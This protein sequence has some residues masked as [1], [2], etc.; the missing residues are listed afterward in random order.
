MRDL[1]ALWGTPMVP[2]LC[3]AC[4]WRYL[5]AGDI[6]TDQTCPHCASQ[7]L[8]ELDPADAGFPH[9]YPPEL[10]VPFEVEAGATE[11]RVAAF[12]EEIPF[13]PE[14]LT[15]ARLRDRLRFLFLPMWMVDVDAEAQ[16]QA[17]VGFDYEVVS[18]QERYTDG[19]GW[20][21]EEVRESRIRWEPRVG[22]LTRRYENVVAPALEGHARL[23]RVLGAYEVGR[24]T[25]YDAAAVEHAFVRAPDRAPDTAWTDAELGVRQRAAE[26]C[27]RAADADHIREFRWSLARAEKNWT[28]LLL[29]LFATHYLDDEGQ[30]HRVLINGQSGRLYGS[31]RG[32]MARA[33]KR[34]L[35]VGGI[36]LAIFVVGMIVALLSMVLPPALLIGVL[37]AFAGLLVGLGALVPI[38]RVWSF[39]RRQGGELEE[40]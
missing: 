14:D 21:T 17:D 20:R 26:E 8:V 27:R 24:A 36:G 11:A 31:K 37:L 13:A 3:E 10:I 2:V 33:Q 18:H 4:D 16:W 38:V 1:T 6:P 15:P 22:R 7:D 39:N 23:Q 32:S 5:V 40:I 25:P 35:L 30:I 28:L 19:V 9:A 12:A 29:P 34:A